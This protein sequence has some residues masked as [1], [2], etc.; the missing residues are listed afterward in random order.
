[1]VLF[2][3]SGV[4]PTEG[5]LAGEVLVR[6]GAARGALTAGLGGHAQGWQLTL[7]GYRVRGG[8]SMGEE[9]GSVGERLLAEAQ[10]PVTVEL[11]RLSLTAEEISGL[12]PGDTLLLGRPPGAPLD[13]CAG[14]KPIAR[15]ELVD[16]D[17]E[18]G[19]RVIALLG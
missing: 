3:A 1:V 13:L 14:G 6:A 19:F 7:R 9:H 11:G 2:E 8:G 17:G 4:R 15:G 5:G 10:V 12:R 18:L 16:V